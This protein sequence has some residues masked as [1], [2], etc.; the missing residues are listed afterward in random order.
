M[1][2]APPGRKGK[3]VSLDIDV[4]NSTWRICL[5]WGKN[6]QPAVVGDIDFQGRVTLP[7]GHDVVLKKLQMNGEFHVREAHFSNEKMSNAIDEL[8]RRGQGKVRDEA[9]QDVAAEVAGNF[10]F[11]ATVLNFR[12]LDF[13]VPGVEAQMK[14][15][16]GLKSEVFDFT[17]DVRLEATVSR[18]IGGAKGLALK[19][20]DPIFIKHAAGTYLPLEIKGSRDHP[21]VKVLWEKLF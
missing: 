13:T 17:G 5:R 12:R 19:P 9:I 14:G 20:C 7:P 11:Q 10:P 3:T 8:S 16:Y 15:S 18:V 6:E 2:R 21:Q 1:L 4:K